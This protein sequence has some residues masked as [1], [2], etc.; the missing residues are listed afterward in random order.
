MREQLLV[1]LLLLTSLSFAQTKIS[2]EVF[3]EF[4]EPVPFANV[5]FKDSSEGT[6]TN[7]NGRFYLESDTTYDAA[8]VSF[9]GYTTK[10]VPL[11]SRTT[12]NMKIE[13]AEEASSL[14]EVV[15]FTGKQSKKDNPAID[16]LRKIWENRR[17][18]GVKKF[19]QY[20]YEKYEKLEFDLNSIDSSLIKSK[21]FRGMEFIFDQTDTSKITGNTY[22]PIFI[23]EAFSKIYGDNIQKLQ[24][25]ILEGNKN[26]GFSNNQTIIEFV[27]DLYSEY[28]VY[29]N[30]IKFFDKA[31]TS[32]LSRTGINVYNYVL[33]DSA[34]IGDKWCYNIVYYPRR[35]NELTFKGDFW[36]NDTTWA[37][38]EINMQASKSANLNW[39]REVYIEQEFDVLNDSIFLIT[40]DYFLSDFSIQKK[41]GARGI[42][43][44]RT[45]LYDNY[46]FDIPKERDFYKDQVDPYD[47]EVYNRPDEFWDKNRLEALNKDEKQI[48]TLLDTLKTVP[49]FKTLYNIGSV[50]ASGYYEF[51][52]FDF[53]PVFSIFGFNEAEGLRVRLGGRTYFGR[54][55]MWRIEGFGA[56]GF[57]DE[58]FKFGLSGKWL[59]DR[60][61]RFI[62]FGGHRKDTEQTGASL[63]N[64]NDVL[65][66]N[67]ASSALITVGANDRLTRINLS[68][69]GFEFEPYKNFVFRTTGSFRTLTSATDTF[70]LD[71]FDENGNVQSEVRQ[72]ELSTGLFYTPGRKTSG[73]GVERTVINDGGFAS[74][75]V[76]ATFGIKDVFNSDFEYQKLQALYTQPWNIGGFGRA[77]TTIEVGKIFGEVPL[78]LLS[79]IPGNQT[80]FS[81]YNTFNQLDFYEFVSDTYASFHLQHDFG[82]R[83][84]SRIPGLRKLN[85]REVIGFRAVYGEISDANIALN[86]SNIPYQAPEDIY[87]EWS[88][89]IGNIFKIFRLDFNFRGNYLDNPD[90]RRFGI[91]GTFG[92]S[93]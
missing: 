39:V 86:A 50:L 81:I 75:F 82:G 16:I 78:S 84:F 29:D 1:F 62:I 93:F 61:S 53:G 57:R 5:I 46:Q 76:G 11:S 25:E 88:V 51:P 30:Y 45:T 12:Y 32:P 44:K 9:L 42:Y 41:E 73:Y 52:N 55:D 60:R 70:S 28:D 37:I 6:I 38:K 10:E 72:A 67:L 54:N 14:G 35:K 4:G 19:N 58:R 80:L 63:T 56:Y 77:F 17:E 23:N 2:G 74:I 8:V 24:K 90:A 71:Y 21:I 22:L 3:D 15:V 91:T 18:N 20:Q 34:Y 64:T 89:G 85:L 69:A 48:Y 87:W 36:V 40:R 65:G 49:R 83:F 31:F 47:F 59:L 13:L 33:L 43:G 79:P 26:S 92:F 68:T 7:E 27:K 66:R